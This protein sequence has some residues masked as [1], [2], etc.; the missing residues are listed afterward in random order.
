MFSRF[1]R[2]EVGSGT[3]VSFWYK[4]WCR[5]GV[6]KEAFPGL[7]KLLTLRRLL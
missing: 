1:V 7:Y 4:W 3:S 2:F 5:D 6:L